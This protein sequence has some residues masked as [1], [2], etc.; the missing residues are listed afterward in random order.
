MVLTKY[1]LLLGFLLFVIRFFSTLTLVDTGMKNIRSATFREWSEGPYRDLRRL[2]DARLAKK[3]AAMSVS[4]RRSFFRNIEWQLDAEKFNR[5]VQRRQREVLKRDAYQPLDTGS[6]NLDFL[7]L[8]AKFCI[9]AL[10]L[11]FLYYDLGVLFTSSYVR[12]N[13]MVIGLTY[14]VYHIAVNRLALRE[15]R[16]WY[17]RPWP[18]LL[19]T[20]VEGIFSNRYE[21]SLYL[22]VL[23][24]NPLVLAGA[25]TCFFFWERL[26][27]PYPFYFFRIN[28]IEPCK[29]GFAFV[30]RHILEFISLNHWV[31]TTP[32]TRSTRLLLSAIRWVWQCTKR[33]LK[34]VGIDTAKIYSNFRYHMSQY[35]WD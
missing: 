6:L 32:L 20:Y 18:L 2:I 23:P 4:G 26:L 27:Q 10:I 31:L 16:F 22:L 14:V 25:F 24:V 17:W 1:G 8:A 7:A 9:S 28:I 30:L 13:Y 3:L 21:K 15:S 12:Y 11:I 5:K 34:F 19:H 33:A 35:R 29:I